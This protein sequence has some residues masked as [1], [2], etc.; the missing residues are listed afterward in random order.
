MP[1]Q[2]QQRRRSSR[3]AVVA[4][5][6][7]SSAA[8][9]FA[10]TGLTYDQPPTT[11]GPTTQDITTIAMLLLVQVFADVLVRQWLGIFIALAPIAVVSFWPMVTLDPFGL[12]AW[13]VLV[14]GAAVGLGCT[15][16]LTFALR[17]TLASERH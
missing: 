5:L 10:G 7:A 9:W 14:V 15:S 13:A 12:F 8:A 2:A 17:R 16:A 4:A 11:D 3:L 1:Q 6:C